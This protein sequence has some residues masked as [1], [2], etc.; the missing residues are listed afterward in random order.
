MPAP[1]RPKRR[2]FRGGGAPRGEDRDRDHREDRVRASWGRRHNP[3]SPPGKDKAIGFDHASTTTEAA[4][5]NGLVRT[6]SE[7]RYG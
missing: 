7:K 1:A 5:S 4:G 6:A 2:D 3:G